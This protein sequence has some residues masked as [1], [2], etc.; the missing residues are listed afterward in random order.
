MLDVFDT[1]IT[2]GY[3]KDEAEFDR[4]YDYATT[5]STKLHSYDFYNS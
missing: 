4:Y 5:G 2:F 3:T 1:V